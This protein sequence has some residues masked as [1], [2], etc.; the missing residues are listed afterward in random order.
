MEA[1]VDDMLVKSRTAPNHVVDLQETFNTL[2]QFQ[3]KLNRAK[4]AFGVTTGKFFGFMI[5]RRGIE[6]NPEKIK[7]IFE[8]TSSKTIREQTSSWSAPSFMGKAQRPEKVQKVESSKVGESSRSE[9]VDVESD[10]EELWT[11]HVDGSSNASGAGAELI[12]TGPEGDIVGYALRF[13]FSTINNEA[14]YEALIAGLKIIREARAQHLKVPKAENAKVDA[15]S[16]LAALLPIDLENETYFEV[17]KTSSLEE[18][19]I[20]QQIDEKSC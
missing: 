17:L 6:I 19:L 5:L 14:E 2:R 10:L 20:V 7:A 4:C 16:K 18:P 3:M 12:L 15:L 9:E 8:M 13:N 1:Y 11:L